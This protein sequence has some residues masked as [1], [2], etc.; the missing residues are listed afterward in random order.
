MLKF[1]GREAG[2]PPPPP[3]RG[4]GP[5]DPPSPSLHQPVT[6]KP[7]TSSVS[8]CALSPTLPALLYLCARSCSCSLL[9]TLLLQQLRHRQH[10]FKPLPAAALLRRIF[11]LFFPFFLCVC[12]CVCV[13]FFFL[14]FF[15]SLF[16]NL[17]F[18]CKLGLAFHGV[19]GEFAGSGW[20][21]C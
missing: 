2:T 21:Q 12:V 8:L 9:W 20:C 7:P 1:Q 3:P 17:P 19:V 5:H 14:F 13:F 16:N 10:A 11:C 6:T 18:S 15:A 4:A